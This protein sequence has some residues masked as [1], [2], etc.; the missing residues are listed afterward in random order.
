[1]ITVTTIAAC[2][3][4]DWTA[5]GPGADQAAEKHTKQTGHPTT[6]IAEPSAGRTTP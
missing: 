2:R 4:C 1:M 5:S 3:R 6:T